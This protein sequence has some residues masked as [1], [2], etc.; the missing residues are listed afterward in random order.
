[1]S[2]HKKFHYLTQKFTKSQKDV[3][4]DKKARLR[5]EMALSELREALQMTQSQLGEK[6]SIKQPAIARTEQRDDVSISHLRS[7]IEAMGGELDL[8]ARFPEGEVKINDFAG[9]QQHDE[10]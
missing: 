1:M 9:S 3:V 7:I 4:E 5:T 8:V 2:R 10:R 6:L